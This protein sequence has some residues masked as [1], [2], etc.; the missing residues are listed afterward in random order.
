MRDNVVVTG[1]GCVSSLGIGAET[2]V[3]RLLAGDTGIRP[4]TTFSTD[5]CRSHT[6]ALLRDFDPGRF[7]DPMKLRRVDEGGRLALAACRLAIDDAGLPTPSDKVGVVLGTSTSGL[8]STVT[9]LH[10]LAADGPSAVPAMGFSNTIGN[11]AASLCSIEFGLRGPNVTFGQKQ[12]SALAALAFAVAGLR[13]GRASAFVCGGV[14]DIEERFFRV[15]DRLHVLSPSNGGEEASRPFDVRRNGFVLGT[16]GHLVVLETATSAARRGVAAYGEVLGV[17]CGGSSCGLSAWPTEPS[18]IVHVMRAALADAGVTPSEVAV[19]FAAA[20]ST[21]ALDSVEALA[22]AEVFGPGGVP[23]VALK[24]ALGE[25]GASGGAA[26]TVALVGLGRGMLPPT[27]GC[28]QPDPACPVDVSPSARPSRG[29][30][31]LIN[32]T[33]D[34]GAQFCLAVRAATIRGGRGGRGG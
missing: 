30:V 1:A 6:A 25:F 10:K 27:L 2:F 11:A 5:R 19:V 14:D 21:Q 12:S 34:G 4:V 33:S 26:L 23:V 20:N 17:G 32:G 28:G 29:S 7:L 9:H 8:H 15:H 13:Q 22:L 3:D 16:G 18:G 31:A 24:G